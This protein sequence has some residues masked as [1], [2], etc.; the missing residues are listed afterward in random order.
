MSLDV[1]SCPPMSLDFLFSCSRACLIWGNTRLKGIGDSVI[2]CWTWKTN[3]SHDFMLAKVCLLWHGCCSFQLRMLTHCWNWLEELIIIFN[4]APGR[5]SNSLCSQSTRILKFL[6]ALL[7]IV[8]L[9]R[10]CCS[11]HKLRRTMDR[12]V[13]GKH[14]WWYVQRF[15][16]GVNTHNHIIAFHFHDTVSTSS[17]RC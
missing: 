8:S 14:L 11:S 4:S 13:G 16:R 6:I 5:P 9:S 10:C 17:L 2:L 1:P 7:F 15:A 12:L 3:L